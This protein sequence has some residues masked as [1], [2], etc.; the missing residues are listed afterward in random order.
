MNTQE[1][2]EHLNTLGIEV[3]KVQISSK[4]DIEDDEIILT[5]GYYL[6][7]CPYGHHIIYNKLVDGVIRR[8]AEG[9]SVNYI[10]SRILQET[11]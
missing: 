2:A 10:Y 7:V 9:T 11:R 1:L 8:I 6:Q 3:T 5:N 4:P